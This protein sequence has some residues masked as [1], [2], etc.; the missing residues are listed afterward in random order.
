VTARFSSLGLRLLPLALPITLLVA[1]EYFGRT[2]GNVYLPPLSSVLQTLKDDWFFDHTVA[3]L[4]PSLQRFVLGYLLGSTIGIMLGIAIGSSRRV[5]QFLEPTLEFLRALPAVAIIPV[6]VLIFGLGGGMRISVIVFGVLFPVLVNTTVGAR[7]CRQE[8]I[9]VA[10]MYGLSRMQI[11]RR[12]VL[13][14]ALPMISTG[15]R[16]ALPIALIM[17]VVSE[18]VGGQ[19]GIGFYLLTGQSLF[20]I[21]GMF[22]AL[23][24]LGVLGNIINAGYARL[25]RRWLFWANNV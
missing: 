19:N 17:M 6:A 4:I 5:A 24:I 3:D 10:R 22:A 13:P 12:V 20:N 11:I 25:E 2:L 8:R 23:F 9:D 14:S 1:W 18:L 15:L 21:A 16:V 7:S